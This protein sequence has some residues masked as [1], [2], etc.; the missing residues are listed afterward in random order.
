MVIEKSKTEFGT[1]DIFAKDF[2]LQ[3]QMFMVGNC[4]QRE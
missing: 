1:M 4:D 2:E 3:K